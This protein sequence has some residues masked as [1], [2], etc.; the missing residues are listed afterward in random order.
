VILDA[1]N[2]RQQV[3]D[4]VDFPHDRPTVYLRPE[5]GGLEW[6]V[7]VADL[8]RLICPTPAEPVPSPSR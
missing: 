2:G 4:I 8:G 5:H 3:M 7:A 6:T 1:V